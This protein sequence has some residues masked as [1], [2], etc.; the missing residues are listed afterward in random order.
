MK[1]RAL[2]AGLEP[3]AGETVTLKPGGYHVMM[4]DL[5]DPLKE[6]DMIEITLEFAKAGTVTVAVHGKTAESGHSAHSH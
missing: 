5:N 2:Q 4:F 6:C 3:S 1:M